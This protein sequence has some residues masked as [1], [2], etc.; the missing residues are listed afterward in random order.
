MA[1]SQTR[2]S[3]EQAPGP[4]SPSS[5]SSS[6]V[7]VVEGNNNAAAS[8]STVRQ[9]EAA[10]PATAGDNMN[11]NENANP[12]KLIKELLY[13]FASFHAIVTPVFIT[14][15]LSALA[16][17]YINDEQTLAAGQASLSNT[18]EVV[19]LEEGSTSQNLGAR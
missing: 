15:L 3:Q 13:S 16:V 1:E 4:I 17:V 10:S 14:M 19:E 9:Q 5:S 7:E 8:T 18:Y 12:D 2:I 6:S 11:N